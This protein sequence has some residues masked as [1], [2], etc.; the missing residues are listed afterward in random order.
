MTRCTRA[1][2]ADKSLASNARRKLLRQFRDSS[3]KAPTLS[4]T[5]CERCDR[6]HIIADKTKYPFTQTTVR[7]LECVSQGY[8]DSETAGIVEMTQDT[9]EWHIRSMMKRFNALSRPHLVAISISLGLINP[10]D[11][12]PEQDEK[13]HA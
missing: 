8:R 1:A 4:V 11:F 13:L 6:Y 9:V 2:Y 12:V 10:N 7:I 5:Y 3:Q